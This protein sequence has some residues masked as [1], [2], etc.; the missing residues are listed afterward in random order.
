MKDCG[1][2]TSG[3][4]D[5]SRKLRA[6]AQELL[7]RSPQSIYDLDKLQVKE[8]VEELRIHQI[9]LEMQNEDLIRG[10]AELD[11]AREEYFDLYDNAPVGYI[12]S[13]VFGNISSVN[14]KLSE[15]LH[16]TK[17][18][19]LKHG[20]APF[21]T[22]HDADFFYKHCRKVLQ[23]ETDHAS[24]VEITFPEG[25]AAFLRFDSVLLNRML[26]ENRKTIRTTIS[27]LTEQKRLQT[28]VSQNQK[29]EALGT[30]AGGIAHDFNNL[31]VPIIGYAE[32]IE[33][34][35]EH[36]CKEVEYAAAIVESA[37][38]A[39]D[40]IEKILLFSRQS[41]T[42][43]QAVQIKDVMNECLTLVRV[44]IAKN[45]DIRQE[46]DVDLPLI[47]ADPSQLHQVIMNL[48]TNAAQ[49]MPEGGKLWVR[50]N[51]IRNARL[52]NG[53]ELLSQG[54]EV[55][56][57]SVEDNGC[58]M[59]NATL[60][61]I[62]EP[63]YTTREK[64]EQRGTGLGLAIVANIVKQRKWHLDV[65]SNVGEGTIFRIYFPTLPKADRV[66]RKAKKADLA[67]GGERIL[68][69]DDDRLVNKVGTTFLKRLGFE[70]T[71]VLDSQEALK[72]FERNARGYQL[73]ITDYSM[74]KLSGPQLIRR[75]KAV[76]DDVPVLLITGYA[77]LATSENLQEWGCEGIIAKPFDVKQLSDAIR[78]VLSRANS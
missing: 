13:D 14:Q 39:R 65:A 43:T 36:G 54:E 47:S 8:L 49:A 58:G 45:I 28:Q 22:Q 48:C 56:C 73:V 67:P 30:L 33:M 1:S 69:V 27:D 53:L 64:G 62:Y 68:L 20:F 16:T 12:I 77:N 63:F 6:R 2:S 52:V 70:V 25:S 42:R 44:S 41:G 26:P 38:I 23:S 10:H 75:I 5:A 29:M 50:L 66:A 78:R 3:A 61:R 46:V 71:S 4:S 34:S 76:R 74:A 17:T 32:L 7:R 51:L 31:L 40:L 18:E 37:R 24:E 15:I 72:E 19:L 55:I 57:L 11:K 59:D 9:E 60:Q 35:L 21:L